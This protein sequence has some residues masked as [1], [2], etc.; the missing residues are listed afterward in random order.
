MNVTAENALV[1]VIQESFDEGKGIRWLESK[2]SSLPE[3]LAIVPEQLR[4]LRD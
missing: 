4:S 3:F 1:G 2:L